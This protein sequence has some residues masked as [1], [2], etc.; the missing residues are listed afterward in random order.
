[1]TL[2]D[3][4][5]HIACTVF[6]GGCDFRCPYCHNYELAVGSSD[7]VMDEE[8]F[9]SFLTT[10]QGLLDGVAIT[11]GEPLMRKDISS[12][13]LKIRELGFKVKLD[14]NGY[15]PE[16]LKELLDEGLVDYVAMDV[17]NSLSKY[18]ITVGMDS[19][20]TGRILQSISILKASDTPYEFRTTVVKELHEDSD[21]EDIGRMIQDSCAY[22]LQQFTERDTVPDKKLSSPTETDMNRYLEI[23]KKYVPSSYLRGI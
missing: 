20:D 5:G 3:F 13:I 22:Y 2:L 18:G 8:K 15:H 4:P 6:L 9:F 16:R 23:V 11:G 19:I 12:F 21:F 10:R 7:P 17:K 1:M 14:T